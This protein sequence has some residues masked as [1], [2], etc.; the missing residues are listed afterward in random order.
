MDSRNYA[1]QFAHIYVENRCNLK[2]QHCYESEE[3]HPFVA[4]L[5]LAEY[6]SI[7]SQLARMGVFVVTFSGG[8]PFL[9]R[10]FLEIV[11]LARRHRFAVRIYT[12]GT[13]ITP[14]KAKRL[15]ELKV[16]EVHL[17]LYSHDAATHDAFT[18][19]PGSHAKT[20]RAFHLL[21]EVGVRTVLKSNI[22]TFNVD[23]L[24][25]LIALAK[26]V[27]ADYRFD[28]TVK[29]RMNGDRS[30]L[31]FAV[32]PDELRRKVLWRADLASALSAEEAE[33]ICDGENH[34]SGSDK[35]MCAAATQ[36]I[37]INADGSVAPCA[38]FPLNG[39]SFLDAPIRDIWEKS[40]L[41]QQVRNQ[42]FDDMHACG[43]CE[44]QASCDPC[45]AYGIVEHGD[46]RACNSSSRQS[47]EGRTALAQQL[48]NTQRK[49]RVGRALPI[50]G[51]RHIVPDTSG[52]HRLSTEQ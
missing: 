38:M 20:M 36:L 13:L 46:Q 32:S 17:S 16:Q 9:R 4:G 41:F 1:P 26:E 30:P 40:P 51:E 2:C 18:Q 8:E 15:Q 19:I 21:G 24:D 43:T 44:A 28:P 27:G 52:G 37:T 3:S 23:H 6:D 25:E 7:L 5:G 14:E 35:S 12:S 29:P 45:M 34:R 47:A 49:S 39:G 48:R 50:F 22:M 31:R 42:R 33:G 10:D 11:A